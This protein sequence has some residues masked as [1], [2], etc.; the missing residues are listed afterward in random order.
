MAVEDWKPDIY[1]TIRDAFRINRANLDASGLTAARTLTLPDFA[2][3]V[4]TLAGTETLSNKRITPRVGTVADSATPTPA[5]DT[6]DQF[7]V[8]A[9]AQAAT[10]AAP[11]GTPVNGQRLIIRILDNGTPR[12]LSWN[13]IYVAVGVTLPTTTVASKYTYVG[14]IYNSQA[15]K[16]D[17]IAV[18]TQA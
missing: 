10:F 2:G 13:A 8:T 14:C 15:S 11:T 4:G 3:T 1:G 7:T 12:A 6:N 16:W 18:A 17:C 5:G 9:L